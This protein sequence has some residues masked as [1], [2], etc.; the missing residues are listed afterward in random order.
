[1]HPSPAPSPPRILVVGD[2]PR[3]CE[4]IAAI[5]R[6]GGFAA[7]TTDSLAGAL[8]RLR[9]ANFQL[10]FVDLDT[11][12]QEAHDINLAAALIATA[13]LKRP[14]IRVVVISGRTGRAEF[15][16]DAVLA[17]PFTY[18]RV[19]DVARGTDSGSHR[20]AGNRSSGPRWSPV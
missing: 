8:G 9:E 7:E 19:L 5:L 14:E 12:V 1:M 10:L 11:H 18:Q 6:S 13:R 2:R 20:P 15:H 17:K 16:A 3:F 4:I